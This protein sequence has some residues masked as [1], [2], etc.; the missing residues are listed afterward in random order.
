MKHLTIAIN[1]DW[2]KPALKDESPTFSF[3]INKEAMPFLR[4]LIARAEA[5]NEKQIFLALPSDMT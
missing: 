1:V 4:Y 2:F 3:H 5:L